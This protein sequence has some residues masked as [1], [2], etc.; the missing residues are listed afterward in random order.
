[1]RRH[2]VEVCLRG[3]MLGGELRVREELASAERGRCPLL[4]A[5]QGRCVGGT[6]KMDADRQIL[7]RTRGPDESRSRSGPSLTTLDL[8]I[9]MWHW[10]R[11]VLPLWDA[12]RNDI[13]A[14][15]LAQL[16]DAL[17]VLRRFEATHPVRLEAARQNGACV[18]G[19]NARRCSWTLLG[20]LVWAR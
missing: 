1:E 14:G 3:A 10:H 17:R 20:I 18:P 5:G 8:T 16:G 12:Q 6:T 9:P 15:D 13:E 11:T 4:E 2:F 7:V 19:C